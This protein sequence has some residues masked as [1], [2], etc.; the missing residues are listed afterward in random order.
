MMNRNKLGEA[1]LRAKKISK[2]TLKYAFAM[3]D[4]IGGDFAPLLVKLGYVSDEDITEMIGHLSGMPTVDISSLIIPEK[5]VRAI[6][7]NVIEKHIVIPITKK[8]NQITLAMSKIDDFEAIEEVQFLT[9]CRVEPVLASR[10]AIRKAIVQFY[11]E[12]DEK[13]QTIEKQ[14]KPVEEILDFI[15]SGDLELLD[16]QK[17]LIYLLIEKKIISALELKALLEKIKTKK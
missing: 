6:P 14:V 1:L 10:E 16:L 3:H 11:T 13:D 5:L 7:R 4:K 8:D 17:C 9:S 12:E 15:R 2:D